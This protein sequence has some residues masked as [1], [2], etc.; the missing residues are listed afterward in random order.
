[1]ETGQ[2]IIFD[3]IAAV[4]AFIVTVITEPI[5][6][7]WLRRLKFGQ[8]IREE[9]PKWHQKKSG[10]PTMG[11]IMF[12]AGVAFSVIILLISMALKMNTNAAV[13]K[14]IAIFVISLGFGC[15]GF[16]DDYIKVVKKR[17]LGL[18][19]WQKFLFQLILTTLYIV[20]KFMIEK[21]F[22]T[23]IYV[24][25]M[26]DGVTMP[27]WL[28]VP[29]IMFLVLGTVNAVNLTDGL[30]GLA[31]SVTIIAGLF[32]AV[33]SCAVFKKPGFSY[34]TS[35]LVGALVAFLI[36]N[37]YPAKVFMGD[38]GSLFLGAAIA[39][40]AIDTGAALFLI[41]VGFV[42][43]ME[44]L[45]VIIQTTYFRYTKKK[46]GEGRRVFKMT[47]IHHHFEMCGWSE[48]KIVFVFT[49]VTLAL[50]ILSWFGLPKIQ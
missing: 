3:I 45:S 36:F 15:I 10:T 18:T 9:G 39:L 32:F 2:I 50:S 29:F 47:P 4:A 24:P 8:E 37:K 16:L 7:K 48:K 49:A 44:T 26:K 12:I 11:G 17:N 41:P 43:L 1:M 34:F 31:T 21:R 27:V 38:T 33:S 20:I 22:N 46:Y 42:Y 14:C 13:P 35:A 25:F 23:K 5:F 19:A 30:D 40:P 28:Y 6:I